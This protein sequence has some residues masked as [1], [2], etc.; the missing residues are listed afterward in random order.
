MTPLLRVGEFR[1]WSPGPWRRSS[2]GPSDCRR[3]RLDEA[4]VA[5]SSGGFDR[6]ADRKRPLV[7]RAVRGKT[8]HTKATW[9]PRSRGN[10][11]PCAGGGRVD[12][13]CIDVNFRNARRNPP[14]PGD[15]VR[16]MLQ[17]VISG[18]GA[19]W[20]MS[21]I[22]SAG[23]VITYTSSGILNFRVRSV[24]VLHRPLLLLPSH[25]GEVGH[26]SRRLRLHRAYHAGARDVPVR[27]PLPS[28]AAVLAP[29]QSGGDHRPLGRHPVTGDVIFGNQAIPQAPG[30]A[31]EPVRVYHFIGVPVTL[32]QVIVYISVVLTVV[33]GALVLR[34]TD[35]GLKVRAMV[36]SPAMT[37]LSGTNPTVVSVS[38]WAVSIFFAGLA[39]VLRPH[40]RARR[41]KR[42]APDR[43]LV[44]GGGSGQASKPA[45]RRSRGAPHGHCHIAHPALP[46]ASQHVDQRDHRCRSVHRHRA[47]AH[48]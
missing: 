40:H 37:N 24:G 15:G 13:I 45:D 12:S 8:G 48:L 20:K 30:L 4:A 38:V 27:R 43:R 2:R 14:V 19:R 9:R 23:L 18:I 28:S 35:L 25:S 7:S 29:D 47:R 11:R 1:D 22:A 34:Y 5:P 36:D 33:V 26:R 31:P 10:R 44:R 3:P 41:R 46:A 32:D 42:H 21:A 39:G 6:V 16:R 17:L